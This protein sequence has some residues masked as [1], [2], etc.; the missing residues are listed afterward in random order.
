VSTVEYAICI[1]TYVYVCDCVCVYTV[2]GKILEGENF[3]D[4]IPPKLLAGKIL[5]NLP[6]VDRKNLTREI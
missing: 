4:S 3:G 6:V 5:A 2:R 1:Y